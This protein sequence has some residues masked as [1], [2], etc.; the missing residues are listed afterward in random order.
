MTEDKKPAFEPS[1]AQ[2]A[3]LAQFV[4]FHLGHYGP[5]ELKNLFPGLNLNKVVKK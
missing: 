4:K 2:R 3:Q 5:R 1:P